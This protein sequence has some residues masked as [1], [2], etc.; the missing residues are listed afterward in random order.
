MVKV[1]PDELSPWLDAEPRPLDG[2]PGFR[3][4]EPDVPGFRMPP[5][6]S[7]ADVPG[8]RMTPQGPA[9]NSL[10]DNVF[11][12]MGSGPS[13]NEAPSFGRGFGGALPTGAPPATYV[14][15]LRPFFPPFRDPLQEAFDQL[16]EIY[17]PA[18]G[19]PPSRDDAQGPRPDVAPSSSDPFLLHRS[20]P[21]LPTSP[22]SFSLPEP[23]RYAGTA[24]PPANI[25]PLNRVSWPVP[26]TDQ[27]MVSESS[28]DANG[29][30]EQA[31]QPSE[32]ASPSAAL[33]SEQSVQSPA[34]LP[35]AFDPSPG[36]DVVDETDSTPQ[37]TVQIAQAKPAPQRRDPPA[38]PAPSK[39]GTAKL[40]PE[41]QERRRL[42]L[43]ASR[44]R[45][46]QD[47]IR[48]PLPKIKPTDQQP[49][50]DD[51]QGTLNTK[52]P[53]Y[54]KWTN[55]AAEKYGIPPLLLARMMYKESR[56]EKDLI[57]PRGARGIAQLMPDAV[58]EVG[59][60]PAKF[61]YFDAEKSI[62]AGAALLAKYHGQLKDWPKA[63]VA[64]NMGITG[65]SN[66]FS[67]QT[68]HA[69]NPD[70]KETR[71]TLQHIFR[72]DPDAFSR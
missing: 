12:P 25:G 72:G 30:T 32:E 36:S 16:H 66:W 49:L 24:Q 41:E 17:V 62:N 44:D 7:E 31:S 43:Q 37:D 45:S 19:V 20:W 35:N 14:P 46:W 26:N 34:I 59:V 22:Q 50:P 67:G 33:P 1:W 5:E 54:A 51:W 58:K 29:Q 55:A 39:P 3:A 23:M 15:E 63:V 38:K 69:S 6:P 13:A 68:A 48:Q 21:M 10:A 18:G 57:S 27:Q 9:N 52:N 28:P 56:Y 71:A 65:A 61:N 8:F 42:A 2:V 70:N 4:E 40:S 53:N 47:L 64:Y 60:D 11:S